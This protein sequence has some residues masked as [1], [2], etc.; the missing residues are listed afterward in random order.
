MNNENK[1]ENDI[2]IESIM[3]FFD[4]IHSFK[5]DISEEGPNGQEYF[6]RGQA[7][8]S[9]S[10]TPCVFRND[11]VNI[12]HSLISNALNRKPTEFQNINSNFEKLT[13]LQHYGLPTRLLDITTN[14]LVALYFACEEAYDEIVLDDGEKIKRSEADGCVYFKKTYSSGYNEIG[15]SIISFLSN[16]EMNSDYT[17][18]ECL[19]LLEKEKLFYHSGMTTYNDNDYKYIINL[20]QT[21]FFVISSMNNERLLKQSGAFLLPGCFNFTGNTDD[22]GKIK[23]QKATGNLTKEFNEQRIIILS[24]KKT[25]IRQE[26]NFYNI[27]EATLFPELEHQLKYIKDF[28]QEKS[29]IKASSF[30]AFDFDSKNDKTDEFISTS[31]NDIVKRTVKEARG[32]LKEYINDKEIK[33]K[34]INIIR[35]HAFIDWYYK[36]SSVN[37]LISAVS[38]V[39]IKLYGSQQSK[40]IAT[41][42]VNELKE[43]LIKGDVNEN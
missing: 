6:F 21:N 27:N 37:K 35:E 23:V 22:I 28:Q 7:N 29:V 19:D 24:D 16:I 25:E 31:E 33:D 39:L 30:E 10:V 3:D 40:K 17:I 15:V 2:V 5:N 20:L 26:L 43:K 18:D 36:V 11:L 13:K 12:E 42:I 41:A 14:P 34:C 9:W 8:A 4:L 38:R 32:I 1:Y